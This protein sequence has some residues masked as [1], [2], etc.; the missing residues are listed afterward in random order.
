MRLRSKRSR[1]GFTSNLDGHP[2]Y[3]MLLKLKHEIWDSNVKKSIKPQY[4]Q[5]VGNARITI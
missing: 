2:R 3:G 4:L 5:R 1:L